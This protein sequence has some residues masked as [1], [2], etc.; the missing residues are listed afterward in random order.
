MK[1]RHIIVIGAGPGGLTAAMILARQGYRVTVYEAQPEIGGRSAALRAEG[2]TFDTG[3]TFLMMRFILEEVFREAG[4]DAK[5]YLRFHSLDPLYALR[6]GNQVFR[7]S[8]LA[9]KTRAEITRLFPGEE[10]GL[11]RFLRDEKNRYDHLFP[12]LQR[13]YS[14]ATSLVS[15]TLLKAL[16][17]L[18]F[19]QSIM[20]NLGRYFKNEQLKLAFTFQAKYL[21]MSP[22][23]CPALF[24]MLP[25]VEHHLGIDHVEGGLNQISHAMA[26]VVKEWG[27][28]IHTNTPI[29]S[30]WIEGKTVK[31]V[32]VPGVG[33]VPADSVVV[34]ADF[35]HAMTH[36]IPGGLKKHSPQRLA[37]KKY[38]CSTFMM[39]LGLK[40]TYPLDHH[41]IFFAD[42]YRKNLEDVSQ[43]RVLSDDF[44]FY[45]QNAT[46]TDPTL[47]PPGHSTLYA[48]V[49]VPNQFSG[50]AWDQEKP[51]FRQKVLDALIRRT[52]FTDLQENIVFERTV[53]PGDWENGY[54]VYRGATFNLAHT[55]DQL[56]YLRP[57]NKF[58]ELEN[59]F[60]VGG[61]THPGSG[62]PT[63]YESGRI[64]AG[65]IQ[66]QF[67]Q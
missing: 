32:T 63:I 17:H 54:R 35:A 7:P 10:A 49:P 30:L 31:G 27:G 22:W 16:P 58:E 64:S 12:C 34:N 37:K 51:A 67:P 65:L 59:C 25:F 57:R 4:R 18:S 52:G 20:G 5:D 11:D 61:G 36:L 1:P 55:F 24:T 47:A 23:D 53:S 40:K 2:F 26:R 44:S 13:D 6:F 21:G 38:S 9:H 50:I 60:L 39:Y 19:G 15:T 46:V 56:L 14:T 62:L 8:P 33:K 42:D 28:E 3:P 29:D 48:L 66:K 43:R 41:T 45:I